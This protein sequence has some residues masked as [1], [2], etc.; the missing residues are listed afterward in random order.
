MAFFEPSHA[1]VVQFEIPSVPLPPLP[2]ARPIEDFLP[3]RGGPSLAV[4]PPRFSFAV[5]GGVFELQPT[6]TLGLIDLFGS[7]ANFVTALAARRVEVAELWPQTDTF[8]PAAERTPARRLTAADA[9]RLRDWLTSDASFRW[10]EDFDWPI[11]S[12]G[13]R[14][15]FYHAGQNVKIDLHPADAMAVVGFGEAMSLAKLQPAPTDV[16]A[17]LIRALP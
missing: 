7:T 6:P 10:G 15:T 11:L 2:A 13:W 12:R 17:L 4:F 8:T 16:E 1:C 9:L 3:A 14:V 5:C